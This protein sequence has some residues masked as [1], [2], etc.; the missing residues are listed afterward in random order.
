MDNY[1][2]TDRTTALVDELFV[3]HPVH[4]DQADRYQA[5]RAK[6]KELA[7]LIAKNTPASAEQTLAIRA[8]HLA[9]MHANSAIAIHEA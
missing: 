3:F 1:V 6:C 2:P 9:G 4:G 8:I 5:I 7:E